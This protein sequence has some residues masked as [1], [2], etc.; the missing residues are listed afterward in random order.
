[1][2]QKYHWWYIVFHGENANVYSR[3]AGFE[4]AG[5]SSGKIASC[6]ELYFPDTKVLMT[7]A[8]YLGYMTEEEDEARE[9]LQDA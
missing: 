3:I 2:G 5:L 4:T 8:I 1:M 7:N 9:E 6:L